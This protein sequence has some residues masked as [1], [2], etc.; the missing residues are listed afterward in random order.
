MLTAT[1]VR[2]RLGVGRAKVSEL[3]QTG[4]LEAVKIG[5]A[6]NSPYRISEEA[7]A[8]YIER[9]KVVPAAAAS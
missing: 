3:I 7:L 1:Q 2:Q 9:R 4:E 8:A 5:D 6:P